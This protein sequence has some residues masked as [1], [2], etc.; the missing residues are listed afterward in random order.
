[1][2]TLVILFRLMHILSGILW[3]GSTFMLAGFVEPASKA[4][5]PEGAKFMQRLMGGALPIALTI[6][7][8]LTVLAGLWLYWYNSAGFNLAWIGTGAGITFTIG[9]IAGIIALLI[10][11]FGNRPT[12]A[13]LA[14]LGKA[15]QTG[16]KPPTPEQL[17]QLH[18]LQEKLTQG[19]LWIA[20][21][22][23]LTVTTMSVARYL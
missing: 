20:I 14:T 13:E 19:T 9:G 16:G 21:L 5:G 6:A 22:L 18:A 8:P 15:L 3:A 12:A 1:M 17:S 11:F 10:G 23:A 2:S 4:T 7:G